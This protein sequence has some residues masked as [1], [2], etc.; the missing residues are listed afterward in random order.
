M[1]VNTDYKSKG[2]LITSIL[3]EVK[4]IPEDITEEKREEIDEWRQM[5]AMSSHFSEWDE[6]TLKKL[7]TQMK[8]RNNVGESFDYLSFSDFTL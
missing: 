3:D 6:E 8:E 7:L 2:E 4:P 1:L 5:Y